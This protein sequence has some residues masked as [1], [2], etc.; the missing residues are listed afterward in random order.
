MAIPPDKLVELVRSGGSISIDAN[1]YLPAALTPVAQAMS[2]RVTLIVR[3][4]EQ[5]SPDVCLQLARATA[6]GSGMILFEF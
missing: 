5:W 1:D 4:A 2:A 6:S 3:H